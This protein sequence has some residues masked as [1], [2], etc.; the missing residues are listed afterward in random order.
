MDTHI[1]KILE[2]LYAI[3]PTLRAHED[4]LV[5]LISKLAASKP[6]IPLDQA[7]VKR[8]KKQLSTPAA[9]PPFQ[10]TVVMPSWPGYSMFG[11][12]FAGIAALVIAISVGAIVLYPRGQANPRPS[13]PLLGMHIED[14]GEHAFGTLGAPGTALQPES[15]TQSAP[16]G[17]DMMSAPVPPP[18]MGI[19]GGMGGGG[20][21]AIRIAPMPPV[22]TPDQ[23][24][25]R[26][27]YAGDSFSVETQAPVYQRIKGTVQSARDLMPFLQK[28]SA[29]L[30]NPGS[31]TDINMRM[32]Q[33][34]E[35]RDNGYSIN[36]DFAE[37]AIY[38]H[39]IWEKW[40]I[41]GKEYQP[42]TA[43]EIPPDSEIMKIA[44]DFVHAHGIDLSAY[45]DPVVDNQW[46]LYAMGADAAR[47]MPIYAPD[48]VSVLYPLRLEGN[49]VYEYGGIP[50]G[51][52]I[53]V[54]VRDRRVSSV[55]NLVAQHYKKSNYALETDAS[56][57]IKI[58]EQGGGVYGTPEF[59]GNVRDIKLGTPERV[60]LHYSMYSGSEA[61][62]KELEVPALAFPILDKPSD[63]PWLPSRVIVPL[64]KDILEQQTQ[65]L[66]PMP[67]EVKSSTGKAG[68]PPAPVLPER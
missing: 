67:M 54:N 7:F 36:I 23:V 34:D 20:A 33:L 46:K 45:G 25:Y 43:S 2:E 8:L 6:A 13:S 63:A 64:P 29:G 11:F 50:Q 38:V 57:L 22:P 16:S 28:F 47:S 60:L 5:P 35:N 53:T 42:L 65:I 37:G 56:R 12:A 41:M 18:G 48:A 66:P 49:K 17:R 15:A 30:V 44:A 1:Q 4:K 59:E 39:L 32:L 31:F 68:A 27:V 19:G 61:E 24:S 26:Y 51:L 9:K 3:D 21:N 62:G 58:A 10:D 52:S 14:A 40:Q 55:S